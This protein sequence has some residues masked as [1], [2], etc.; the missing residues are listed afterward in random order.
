M[1]CSR[2]FHPGNIAAVNFPAQQP[3]L[4]SLTPVVLLIALGFVAGRLQWIRDTAVRDLSNLVFLVLIPALLF[5]AMSSVRVQ[6][7]DPLPL[8][9][10]F[11]AALGLFFAL[12]ALQGL[13]R[14]AVAVALAGVFSN[15]VMIGIPL[16]ELAYG[17]AGLLTLLTLVSVHALVLL[18]VVTV[19]F[20]LVVARESRAAGQG[21]ASL[22][23]SVGGAVRSAVIHP[24]PLPIL[25]GL[26]FAQTG[27][28]LPTVV[29]KPLQLLA[30][31]F[32]PVAL[33]LVGVTMSRTRTAGLWRDTLWI[34]A[35]KNI[36]FPL[37]V[38]V[39][40]WLWGLRGLPW[41]VMVVTAALP[42][43]ANVFLFAQRYRVAEN[44]VTASVG[45]STAAGL[46]TLSLVMWLVS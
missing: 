1:R 4:V 23:A 10:Y 18:T 6:Q 20:E 27:W 28:T 26:L 37:C 32:S 12:L 40:G 34:T 36:V 41:T 7:L 24:I 35:L 42:V 13:N 43:G 3:V 44:E 29:D 17:Q 16:V 31:A 22:W 11:S 45:V 38:A 46:A 8:M 15:T 5:R 2:G 9:V 39:S 25:A 30:N 14:R 33:L 21:A 19:V